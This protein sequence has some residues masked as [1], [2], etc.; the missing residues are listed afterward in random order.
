MTLKCF[1]SVDTERFV[2]KNIHIPVVFFF[3]AY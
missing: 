2:Y 1:G 3:R